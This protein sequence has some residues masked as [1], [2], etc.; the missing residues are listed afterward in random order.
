MCFQHFPQINCFL[1]N[2][3]RLS[4]PHPN[5]WPGFQFYFVL[6]F[7]MAFTI[8]FSYSKQFNTTYLLYNNRFTSHLDEFL[9]LE[10]CFG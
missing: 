9:Y 8:P 5:D 10:L 6:H 7:N 4:N 1:S 3:K 2:F